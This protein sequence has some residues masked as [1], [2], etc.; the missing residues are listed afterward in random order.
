MERTDV[1][2]KLKEL[3]ESETKTTIGSDDQELDIDSFMMM[4]V[5]TFIDEQFNISLDMDELDFDAFTSLNSLADLV[6]NKSS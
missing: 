3:I 1:T 4:M 2:T 6:V 5:I